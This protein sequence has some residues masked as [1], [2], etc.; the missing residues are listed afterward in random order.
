M[1]ASC[2]ACSG[3]RLMGLASSCGA[4]SPKR[5]IDGRQMLAIERV[6]FRVVRR[7][8]FRTKPPAPVAS[9]RSQQRFLRLSQRGLVRG[10][11]APL[12]SSLY[13]L[14]IRFAR[15][16]E[17]FPCGHVFAVANPN[18]E[19]RVNPGSGENPRVG[20]NVARRGN[21]LGRSERPEILISLDAP[22]KFAQKLAAIPR[23]VFPGIFAIEKQAH[24]EGLSGLH[25]FSKRSK[26][27]MQIRGGILA[28]HAAINET[29]EIG[30][31]VIAKKS[32]DR[33]PPELH[34]Q[35]FVQTFRIRRN[36]LGITK[37]SSVQ[38]SAE[39]TFIRAKPLKSF[40]SGDGQR[41]IRN[42]AF[43]RPEPR[44]LRSKHA[45]VKFAGRA[46]I[47]RGHPRDGDKRAA[48]AACQ[49][50]PRGRYPNR[51]SAEE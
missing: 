46:A 49:G 32:R 22:V 31:V 20:W 16:P 47:A 36:P 9:F 42:R 30:K 7:A 23:I 8:V 14:P 33:F 35:W 15:V 10:A 44:G 17:Q 12:F 43:G 50:W 24:R 5:K 41:L 38:R 19:I 29:D 37:E 1:G 45:L 6:E 18:I 21:R 28:I 2:K 39:N 40:F 4:S 48:G 3:F 13:R 51:K 27:A 11:I 34:A 26:P 25:V